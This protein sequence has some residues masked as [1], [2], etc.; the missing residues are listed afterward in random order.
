M[1][2]LRSMSLN[3]HGYNIGTESYLR[4]LCDNIDVILLQ[5]T[6]MSDCTCS[7]LDNLSKDFT[8][9]RSSA[10]E[11]KISSGIMHGRPFGGT[12]VPLL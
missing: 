3:C 6:W 7:M 10:I 2:A 11:D 12:V 5:E 4:R 8:V 9:F 1:A